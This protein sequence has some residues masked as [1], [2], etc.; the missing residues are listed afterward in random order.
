MNGGTH[1]CFCESAC[2]RSRLSIGKLAQ[3]NSSLTRDCDCDYSLARASVCH[4]FPTFVIRDSPTTH[5][6]FVI[7]I[8]L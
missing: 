2:A 5:T 7:V 8:G 3:S 4:L 1:D 6:P